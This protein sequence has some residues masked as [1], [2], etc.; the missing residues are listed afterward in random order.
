VLA[1]VEDRDE[2]RVVGRVCVAEVGVVVQEGVALPDVV[3]QLR[4]RLRQ[5]LHPDHMDWQPLR[6]GEQLVVGSDERA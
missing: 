6:R 2:D 4:H 5:E 1:V 3:V